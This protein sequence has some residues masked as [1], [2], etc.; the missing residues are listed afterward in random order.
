MKEHATKAEHD[1][2]TGPKRAAA[3]AHG[4]TLSTLASPPLSQDVI[5]RKT[6]ACGG[7][8]PSCEANELSAH[9]VFAKLRVSAADDEFEREADRVADALMNSTH[10]ESVTHATPAAFVTHAT[11]ADSGVHASASARDATSLVRAKAR[12][13]AAADARSVAP[14]LGALGPG[15][16]L[17]T[18]ARDFFEPRLGYDLGGVRVHADGA[19]ARAASGI[20]ARAFASGGD[21]FFGAGEYAPHTTDGRRLIAHEL[22]H[23]VQQRAGG[24]TQI[25]RQPDDTGVTHVF[26]SGRVPGFLDCTTDELD[27]D[28]D[29]SCCTSHTRGLIPGLYAQSREYANRAIRR[30]DDGANMDGAIRRHFGS[31]AL[32]HRSEIR[33]RLGLI[34]AELDEETTHIVRCRIARNARNTIGFDLMSSVDPR[35]LCQ[36]GVLATGRVGGNV[37]TLCVDVDGNPV[38]G[39]ETL[40]H[41]MVHLAGIGDLPDRA[42]ATPA[43]TTAREYETYEHESAE[44]RASENEALGEV[45][46]ANAAPVLYPNPMPFALRNADSYSSFVAQI[47][48]PGWSAESNAAA[49]LPTLEAGPLMTFEG[50]PRFGVAGAMHWTPFG[51]SI[52]PIIGARALWLPRREAD[53]SPPVEPTDLRAYV[54]PELGLRWIVGGDRVQFVLDVAGGAGAYVTV[55]E[56]VDPALSARLGLGLRVGGPRAAFGIG[57]DV[58]RLFHF[59]RGALVGDTAEDWLGGLVIRGHWGGSSRR[60]R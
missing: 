48:A 2:A 10:T 7:G 16:P 42:R 21:L 8:C 40:F 47:G 5:R 17:D 31:D 13:H 35:L 41:E 3:S 60:P 36:V 9:G 28:S 23:V 14:E 54:G 24:D 50:T 26:I 59:S 38:S 25:R 45:G 11:H 56:D 1:T 51:S 18:S 15:V 44:A 33:R 58:M 43:Q 29:T 53:A 12:P 22:A 27:A 6:C 49:F 20:G 32:W 4:A 55:D 39:W 34:R 30:M 46:L 19:S 37:A 52:Q 57:A